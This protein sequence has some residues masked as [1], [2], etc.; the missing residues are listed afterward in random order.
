MQETHFCWLDLL[1]L[2]RSPRPSH[3]STTEEE[4]WGAPPPGTLRYHVVHSLPFADCLGSP[5]CPGDILQL[6]GLPG[7]GNEPAK[8]AT[9]GGIAAA[10]YGHTT[11]ASDIGCL[12]TL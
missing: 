11:G 4:R 9:V 3:K 12:S 7:P 2:G 5:F 6:L 8:A 10:L 1:L